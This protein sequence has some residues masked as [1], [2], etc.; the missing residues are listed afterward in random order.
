MVSGGSG[1]QRNRNESLGLRAGLFGPEAPAVGGRGSNS[2]ANSPGAS[3]A[4]PGSSPGGFNIGRILPI[5]AGISATDA[6]SQSHF[7]NTDS[8]ANY[9]LGSS[10]TTGQNRAADKGVKGETTDRGGRTATSEQ[11]STRLKGNSTTDTGASSLTT[12]TS[13]G[14]SDTR[15]NSGSVGG[16]VDKSSDVFMALVAA[17]GG[18]LNGTPAEKQR[19]IGLGLAA[20]NNP[21]KLAAAVRSVSEAASGSPSGRSFLGHGGADRPPVSQGEV[22]A[23]AEAKIA[24]RKA[25]GRGAVAAAGADNDS[26]VAS[27]QVAPSTTVPS[28]GPAQAAV[29]QTTGEVS[30]TAAVQADAASVSAGALSA[31]GAIY[32]DRNSSAGNAASHAFGS[33]GLKDHHSAAGYQTIL[34]NVAQSDP[35]VRSELK[36]IS[37]RGGYVS[38]GQTEFLTSKVKDYLDKQ[39]RN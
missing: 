4:G 14:T 19:A 6:L 2:A 31:G 25:A 10:L 9:R 27:M 30:Q 16:S 22:A 18:N 26:R 38:P 32:R 20:A 5:G 29:S 11:Q 13:A 36:S 24:E 15:T 33:G 17:E 34:N 35:A 1:T 12:T 23:G 39:P 37:E 7:A 8:Q 21:E 3:A 28:L